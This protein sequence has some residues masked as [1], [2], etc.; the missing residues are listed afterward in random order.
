MPC[1]RRVSREP[2]RGDHC[3]K[4]KRKRQ[5][6]F[7]IGLWE[8]EPDAFREPSRDGLRIHDGAWGEHGADQLH[9][10]GSAG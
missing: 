2:A 5:S 10:T 8:I 7:F 9:S 6:G 4:W 3:R 1:W